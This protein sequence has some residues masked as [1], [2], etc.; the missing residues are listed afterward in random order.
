LS[1]LID[2]RTTLE[3]LFSGYPLERFIDQFLHRLPIAL[4][5]AAEPFCSWGQW[6]ILSDILKAPDNDVMVVRANEQY[7]GNLPRNSTEAQVLAEKGYTLL[8]RHAE[9]HHTGIAKLADEFSRVFCAPVDAHIYATPSNQYGF[10]WHYD[11][12]DVFIL[13]LTGEKTYGLRKNTVNP[14]PLEETLP[15]D[16]QYGRELMPLMQVKL[17]AGDMLYIPCGYW[18]R[19]VVG[20]SSETAISLAIGVMSRSAVDVF[21]K[22]R[23]RI[24]DSILWRQRLPVVIDDAPT[25]DVVELYRALFDMLATDLGKTLRSSEFLKEVLNDRGRGKIERE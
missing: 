21:D 5:E 10:S 7:T 24:L 6:D 1:T 4:P 16:M 12:E 2:Q 22:L 3:Q 9:R 13:Q 25:T 11:A 15:H 8:V 20:E 23:P 19:G 17:N 14:W 18:H